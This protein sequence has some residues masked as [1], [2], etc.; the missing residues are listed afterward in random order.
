MPLQ[1]QIKRYRLCVCFERNICHI[2]PPSLLACK[3]QQMNVGAA[4][5]VI[6]CLALARRFFAHAAAFS[7]LLLPIPTP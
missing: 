3:L 7:S 6:C 2:A 1:V 4:M 5:I